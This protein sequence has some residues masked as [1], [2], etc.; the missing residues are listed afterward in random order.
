MVKAADPKLIP[1]ALKERI[2]KCPQQPYSFDCGVYMLH[3][4]E[5]LLDESPHYS[6][7]EIKEKREMIKK[8][9]VMLSKILLVF[10]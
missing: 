7:K 4:F 6:H 9:I 1:V 5:L 8:L 10:E 3:T 2:G